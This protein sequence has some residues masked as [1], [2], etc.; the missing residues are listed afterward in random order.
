[1]WGSTFMKR[2]LIL[3]ASIL[4]TSA[5]AFVFVAAAVDIPNYVDLQ[6]H[7]A[8]AGY[9]TIDDA[10]AIHRSL[11]WSLV[12]APTDGRR[13]RICGAIQ[14]SP[15]Q[16]LASQSGAF[17]TGGRSV[18]YSV[19]VPSGSLVAVEGLDP[20]DGGPLKYAVLTRALP[21]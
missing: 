3:I 19:D 2:K 20:L 18:E 7:P 21:K 6:P 13:Y 17:I 5:Y 16:G 9:R 12:S 8:N 1:M 4:I 14:H 11:G 10:L 15:K